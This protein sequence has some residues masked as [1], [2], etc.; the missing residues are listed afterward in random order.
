MKKTSVLSAAL[1]S[2]A[3]LTQLQNPTAGQAQFSPGPHEMLPFEDGFII[4][5]FK[6]L[7][8]NV[9][10]QIAD[11][12]GWSGSSWVSP[13]AYNDHI[14]SDFSVQTGTP[15]YATVAGT[16]AE[17][18]TGFPR[19]DHTTY[20]GN[21]VRIACDN[22]A[23][24]GTLIDVRYLHMLQVSVTVGQHLNI[25]DQVGLSDNTGDSTTEHVHFQ[26]EPRGGQPT[27][28]FYWGHFKYPIVFNTTG[29]LQ[30]GRV[31]KVTAPS[32]PIRSDRFDTSS[33]ITTAYQDQ[34]FFCSYP[35]RGYY[36]VFIP[37]DTGH[38][39]GWIR[40]TDVDEVF[41]GTVIQP[42]PDA[43]TFTQL[44]QLAA[45]YAIRS[46]ASDAA[47]QI[48]SIVFG[49]GRFVADQITNGYYRIP[50]P[51]ASATWGWVKPNNHMIVY[52]QLT[53]TNINLATL[54][55]N[56]FPIQESFSVLGKSMFGRPKFNR[57][58]VNSFSPSSP[59]GD[60][61]AL[62][63]TDETNQGNGTTESVTVGKPGYTNYFVQSDV[64]FKYKPAYLP[65]GEYERYGIYMRDD[66]FAGMDTTFEG[67]GNGYAL[68]WD[69]DD[70]RIRA[71]K[72]VDG[73]V[74]D[75]LPTITYVTNAGWHTMR[76]EGRGTQI[77]YF[78]DGSLLV[79]VTDS[80][81]FGGQ[82][83]IGYSEH[84]PSYPT[85]RG[86]YFDNFTAYTVDTAPGISTQPASQTVNAGASATFNVIAASATTMTYQWRF[87]GAN[88]SGATNSS[89]M[90]SNVQ[91][92]DLG[93]YSVVV[94]NS[95]GSVT[96]SNATLSLTAG[97]I[98]SEDFEA[99]NM[100][101]WS[102]VSGATSL[103]ISTL[104]NHTSGGTKSAYLNTTQ[105]KMYHNLSPLA[106]GHSK[107]T[108]WIYDS[109]L[110]RAWGEA[111]SYS[112]G[113]FNS[114]SLQQLYAAG[115]YTSV[116]LPGEVYDSTK[117]QGR[118]L[119]GSNVGWFN[120]N[121]AGAPSRSTG[122]HKFE[123]EVLSGGT[124][125]N[126]Y[127]D[128]VLGRQITGATYYAL[129]DVV[130]GSL[131]T[132][133]TT[134]D[135]WF[136]D[137][138][139]EYFDLP[140]ITTQPADQTVNTGS[141]ATFSVA[142]SGIVTS[143]Q[144]L[145]NG[146]PISGATTSSY[147]ISN[148]QASDTGG[149]AVIVSNGVGPVTSTTATLTVNTASVPPSI[150]TQPSS[151][152]VLAGNSVT[153]S[154]TAAGT[155]PLS[156]QW[157]FNAANISGATLSSYAKSNVQAGDAGNYSV[158]VT[159]V[160]GSVTSSN[161]LLTVNT[162]PSI[163]TQPNGLIVDQGQSA[164]FTVVA[165]GSSPLSY[166]WRFNSVNIAGATAS[167]YTRSNCQGSDGGNYS[168]VVTNAYGSVTSGNA[169]LTVNLPPT[170]TTQPQSV[171]VAPGSNATFTVAATGAAPLNYQWQLN[172]ANV[173]GATGTSYT[174]TNVQSAD[175]GHY[176]VGVYNYLGT[177]W[178]T[179]ATLALSSVPVFTETFESG[180]LTNWSPTGTSPLAISTA[181][182][183][184][185][186]GTYS[187]YLNTSLNKMFHNLGTEVEGRS[188]ATFWIYDSTQ[189]RTMGEV[190]S[191]S[192]SGYTNGTLL[193]L[194][195]I[196]RYHVGFGTGT[197]SL[198]TEVL[199][200]NFYQGRILAGTNTGYLNLTNTG[201]PGRS[202]G[203]HKFEIERLTNGTTINFYVDG[204]LGRQIPLAAYGSFDSLTI[205]SVAAG[206]TS[207]DSWFDDIKME[208]FDLPTITT[209]PSNQTV[210][211]GSNATFTVV[212]TGN[213][214]GY[215][216]KFNGVNIPGATG[217]SFTLN[218]V[219]AANAGNYTVVVMNG[220]GPVTSATATLTVQ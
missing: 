181:Q 124:T 101:N 198:A 61:K 147:T 160:A 11:W 43:V 204:V 117:Y 132:A 219:Q 83:G 114:G 193:Q 30:V 88:I 94:S 214:T 12:T 145:K 169:V 81:F 87:N 65:A 201:V 7:Q 51:G 106:G 40:A 35:K 120:L 195:A 76:I 133:S 48:G 161:A 47:S 128:G 186:S 42:L 187:A 127:V 22:A 178:S 199:N 92:A 24:D 157:R 4:E 74:T 146:S 131:G 168:V 102:V 172:Q 69:N 197:G 17:I 21:F 143:Y 111:R 19:N 116:T 62:F 153:F 91:A 196:G 218:N 55:N 200:T 16:V 136:D 15:L 56:T 158:V 37:N 179:D 162:P 26:S 151:Q 167:S 3:L 53:N 211:A 140:S 96:S 77:K 139:V 66:G 135:A 210:T 209:Q 49:G 98:F 82:C 118:V 97:S 185:T 159:N 86:A 60:G 64:Y 155:A 28:P 110:N 217:A 103:S 194:F 164:T 108:F 54:P 141:S 20:G 80:T 72:L 115:K 137:I 177:N 166:Q 129:D 206:S 105:A 126:F 182:N 148:A 104:Q 107:V 180:T 212:A 216:W 215:Q 154:V 119:T 52:P 138:K 173:A 58:V 70:G 27:C 41:T 156:Y 38:K 9:A 59:G 183:H 174:R 85:G 130:I 89:Y 213:V 100:N 68:L 190:R 203:W 95:F 121:A 109:T 2:A 189:T 45:T 123:I 122:W 84:T 39:S 142:T 208:Y 25:G 188:K 75:F 171:T 71:A 192:G 79:Q 14:G 175:V 34:L 149:Y 5:A 78:L 207:G 10:G 205:G 57:S 202:V 1:L 8:T 125:I 23:P 46:S 31:V 50:L 36:Q 67:A 99:G 163:T 13:D 176:S 165:T 63:V 113:T 32:T 220:A 90:K 144:W 73:A 150:T 93:Y 6:D 184:T 29:T 112:G 33:Q 170:I 18:A 44:G 134:G 191:Y 152:T